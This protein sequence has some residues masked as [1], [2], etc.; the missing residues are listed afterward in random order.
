MSTGTT[1]DQDPGLRERIRTSRY[2]TALV[3][4]VTFA[5]VLV[6]AH[7]VQRPADADA[8]GGVTA[9]ELTGS[10]PGEPPAVGGP[11]QDFSAVTAEGTPIS[12][13]G[14]AGHP[15]W[16]TFGASWCATCRAEAPDIEAAHRAQGTDGVRV[17]GVFLNEDAATVADYAG[18]VGLTFPIVADPQTDIASAYRVLGIPAHFFIDSHGVIRSMVTGAM[19]ADRIDEALEE[20]S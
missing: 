3:L 4:T 17:V 19:S 1:L 7:Q 9:V 2:G 11:A 15:V 8:L 20:L 5:V 6:L 16:L 12:L 13:A 18:Q 10:G 14:L